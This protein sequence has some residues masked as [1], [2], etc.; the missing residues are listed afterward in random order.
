MAHHL[1]LALHA[2]HKYC[3]FNQFTREALERL[4]WARPRVVRTQQSRRP[5]SS[6]AQS[7]GGATLEQPAE[8]VRFCVRIQR[9][10][11]LI[12]ATVHESKPDTKA[13]IL[14]RP[15]C[16]N[17]RKDKSDPDHRESPQYWLSRMGC[18]EVTW[19]EDEGTLR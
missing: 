14:V 16:N 9:I 19:D 11:L 5:A 10:K 4:P 3:V 18:G 13:Y 1:G 2:L 7:V 17:P 6:Q 12:Q 15:P 8:I